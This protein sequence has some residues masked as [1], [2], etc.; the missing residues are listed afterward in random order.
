ML[1]DEDEDEDVSNDEDDEDDAD[2]NNNK[3]ERKLNLVG[4]S[5][6]SGNSA[7]CGRVAKARRTALLLR[8][9]SRSLADGRRSFRIDG[10]DDG[11]RGRDVQSP[12]VD[13][14][15]GATRSTGRMG[16]PVR[17]RALPTVVELDD[18]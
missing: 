1:H 9:Q 4:R 6:G 14:G 10:P 5:V 3:N 7:M 17:R 12:S 11:A 8:K 15:D 18:D 16:S 2:E 13:T